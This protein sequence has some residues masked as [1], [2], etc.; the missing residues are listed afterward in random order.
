MSLVFLANVSVAIQAQTVL[1]ILLIS[2]MFQIHIQPFIQKDMNTLEV[3]SVLVS[4]VTIY[5]GLYY[6]CNALSNSHSDTSVQIIL[7]C[8]IV[9]TNFYFLYGVL[10]AIA[11]SVLSAF[12]RL[13]KRAVYR[14]N[15]VAP[16]REDPSQSISHNMSISDFA[17]RAKA[18]FQSARQQSI[19]YI[20][21]GCEALIL[22]LT[23]WN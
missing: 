19:R 7:F 16:T 21:I 5:C 10:R 2:L 3:K 17:V 15:Q 11:P 4:F 1:A 20:A 14:G 18:G 8:I 23:L 6:E 12:W 13:F 22:S 9:G